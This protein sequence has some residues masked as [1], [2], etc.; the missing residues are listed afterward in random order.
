M[1]KKLRGSSAPT[2]RRSSARALKGCGLTTDA[3]A[4]TARIAPPT[5]LDLRRAVT[6]AEDVLYAA[7]RELASRRGPLADALEE[8]GI[9]RRT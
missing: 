3:S 8:L 9:R 6:T 7:D 2:T 5:F 4:R 1:L